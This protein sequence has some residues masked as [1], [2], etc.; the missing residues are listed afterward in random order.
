MNKF[1]EIVVVTVLFGCEDKCTRNE[2]FANSYISEMT[3]QNEE[4]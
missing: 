3:W 4:H 1:E 2:V